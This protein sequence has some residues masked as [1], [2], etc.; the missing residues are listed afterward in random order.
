MKQERIKKGDF[1]W[2]D[3]LVRF[4]ITGGTTGRSQSEILARLQDHATSALI[5]NELDALHLEDKVQRFDIPSEITKGR[6]KI[7]WRATTKLVEN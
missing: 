4:L 1:D 3:Q 5:R 6:A 2:R 7:I